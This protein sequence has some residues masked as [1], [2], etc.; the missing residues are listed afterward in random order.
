MAVDERSIDGVAPN[1][2]P[3]VSARKRIIILLA[4]VAV[5]GGL[6]FFSQYFL[7]TAPR[8]Q[9]TPRSRDPGLPWH[10]EA[11]PDP[12]PIS[13]MPKP[14]PRPAAQPAAPAK[15]HAATK[16][17][18]FSAG[19][20]AYEPAFAIA[21]P[22]NPNDEEN[23]TR[24]DEFT[25][26]MTASDVGAPAEAKLMKHPEFVIPAGAIIPCTLTT[27]INS[28]LMG[29]VNCVTPAAVYGADGSTILMDKGTSLFGQIRSGV[30]RG[31]DR[32]F[33]LW[34]RART[35]DNVT[36]NLSSPAADE[37][38]RAGVAGAVDDHFWKQFGAAALYSLIQYGPSLA[39]AALQNQ[40]GGVNVNT[41]F[42]TPQQQLAS[43]ILDEDLRIPP[44]LTKNQG[45]SVSVFVAR[46]LD[47]HEVYKLRTAR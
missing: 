13:A 43:T 39:T 45:E 36:V 27:A 28:Q 19:G 35:P 16:A 44:T 4:I 22:G 1:A 21:K 5:A 41:T 32:L 40:G 3:Y 29:F 31:Q 8:P 18:I 9:Q 7:G 20:G 38:G 17:D 6:M 34:V 37:P 42:L 46:D 2:R 47:F 11:T 24:Q 10:T 30:R 14:E 33:I 26:A 23:G 25:A 12:V 15:D